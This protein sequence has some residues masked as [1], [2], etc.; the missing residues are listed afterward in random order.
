MSTRYKC[1]ELD[2][3]MQL[4]L[5]ESQNL[6]DSPCGAE[7]GE[8][9]GS[10]TNLKLVCLGR[11]AGNILRLASRASVLLSRGSSSCLSA[12][13]FAL[14][15]SVLD[16]S[17]VRWKAH[18]KAEP[19]FACH[20]RLRRDNETN[21]SGS[22][23]RRTLDGIVSFTPDPV[24]GS[25]SIRLNHNVRQPAEGG[26]ILVNGVTLTMLSIPRSGN[27]NVRLRDGAVVGHWLQPGQGLLNRRGHCLQNM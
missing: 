26:F 3:T 15:P 27:G 4:S 5:R 20:W 25:S 1:V 22:L 9:V 11:Y 14:S 24:F 17:L 12:S 6:R 7:V 21:V 2:T 23:W 16:R 13:H 8:I 18:S 10:T 19:D